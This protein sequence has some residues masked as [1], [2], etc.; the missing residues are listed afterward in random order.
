MFR[1]Y[2]FD[3]EWDCYYREVIMTKKELVQNIFGIFV[4]I[5][6]LIIFW[7][8]VSFGIVPRLVFW[9]VAEIIAVADAY[10]VYNMLTLG[11]T[12][13]FTEYAHSN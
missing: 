2:T 8:V 7:N 6:A 3:C 11:L 1:E 5:I 10:S 12:D 13:S 9:L 4:S